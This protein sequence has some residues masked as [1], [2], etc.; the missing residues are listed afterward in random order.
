MSL[1]ENVTL[2]SPQ[3]KNIVYL[4][5][6]LSNL[7]PSSPGHTRF[8][9]ISDT[10]TRRFPVPDGDVLLH[11]GDLTNTGTLQE[12][13]RTMN[14]IYELPH[15]VKIIIAGNHDLPLHD[16]WYELNHQRWSYSGHAKPQNRER[17]LELLKGK[18]AQEAN[19]VYLQDESHFFQ[20]K[21]GGR[22]W[23]VYGS[24]WSPEFYNWAFGYTAA[25]GPSLISKFHK[26]DILL[27]HGPP[28]DIFDRTNSGDLPG[29]PTL[30]AAL[31]HL[32][33]RLHLFGH[34]H[35]AHGAHVHSWSKGNVG[36][37]QNSAQTQADEP[38]VEDDED[39]DDVTVFVN[40]ANWP[41]GQRKLEYQT[42]A[43]G[44]PGFRPVVV[45]M[46]E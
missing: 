20:A 29:C 40:A 44:R 22:L 24:P 28:R 46:L 7:P 19:V 25:E 21:E 13:E 33:P 34:I 23:S 41:M 18:K 17:I 1:Q 6:D 26:T 36:S 43:F 16:D 39:G 45:D 5:Y 37:V 9:C 14:W 42:K 3:S 15:K 2:R 35:E 4:E 10:H 12:F 27:T 31:P 8:V 30:A 11:S 32:R 38:M